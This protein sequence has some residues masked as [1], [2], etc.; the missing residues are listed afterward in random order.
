[1]KT[2][3]STILFCGI[4]LSS[5]PVMAGG[6]AWRDHQAPF[7]FLFSNHLDTHQQAQVLPD[8]TLLGFLYISFTGET[9]SDGIPYAEHKNCNEYG[10]ECQVGWEVRGIPGV[11][12][13]VTHVMGDHPLW[14]VPRSDIPMPGGYTHFH[15]LG[16]PEH[17]ENIQASDA[18]VSGYFLQLTAKDTFIFRHGNEEI[19]VTNGM[20]NSTHLNI[21]SAEII[22][23]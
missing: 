23:P 19:L 15:W 21:I 18:L 17:A 14:A 8:G 9:N 1:M 4:V 11:A 5:F 22:L 7:D 2:I 16:G 13:F 12:T 6:V 10:A 20:D 3:I